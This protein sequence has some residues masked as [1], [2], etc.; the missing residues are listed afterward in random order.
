M[1]E[2]EGGVGKPVQQEKNG[3]VRGA[4]FPVENLDTVGL[5]APM[6]DFD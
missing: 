6:T 1:P 4:G 5:N 2:I 3:T